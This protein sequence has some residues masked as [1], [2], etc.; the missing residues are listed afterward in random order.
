MLQCRWK[1]RVSTVAH[2]LGQ[3][4]ACLPL[5]HL[6]IPVERIT[7]QLTA[8]VRRYPHPTAPHTHAGSFEKAAGVVASYCRDG[9]ITVTRGQA[10]SWHD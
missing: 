9:A 3:F 4:L 2:C 5:N 10:P 6:L 1:Y 8:K 7:E